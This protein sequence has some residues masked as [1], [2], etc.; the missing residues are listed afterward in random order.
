MKK[1][2]LIGDSIR[3]GY[4]VYVKESMA[5]VAEVYFPAENCRFAAYVLRYLHYWKDELKLHHADAVHWNVGH[6]DTVRIYGDAPITKPEVYHDYIERITLRL[7]FLFPGAK[8]IFATSTPV[9]EAGFI[10]EF[11][12]RYNHD[13]ESYN[14]I[15]CG[16]VQKYGVMINDLYSLLENMPEM[17]HSDQTHFYTPEATKLIGE[18]VS[19]VLAKALDIDENMLISPDTNGFSMQKGT[20][21]RDMYIKR[22][23]LYE[24]K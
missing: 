24:R 10:E 8:L 2:L 21:D 6:W 4:D 18:Q 22:G 11:E 23:N 13:V 16:V 12:C 5:N 1:I 15:A 14:Q 7:M 3:M 9:I 20:Y 17:L 19:R